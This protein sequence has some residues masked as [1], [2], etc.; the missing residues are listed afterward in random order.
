[1]KSHCIPI[2][3]WA[4]FGA[5]GGK[6]RGGDPTEFDRFMYEVARWWLALHKIPH[7]AFDD[8]I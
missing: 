7:P 3:A 4:C 2:T 5:D 8:V 6:A 1:M